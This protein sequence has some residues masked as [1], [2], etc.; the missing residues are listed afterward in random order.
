[1]LEPAEPAAIE[2]QIKAQVEEL[3]RE[4][5]VS[6]RRVFRHAFVGGAPRQVTRVA[7]RGAWK[8]ER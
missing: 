2:A 8:S 1:V 4:Y 5:G 6:A 7:L 3:R